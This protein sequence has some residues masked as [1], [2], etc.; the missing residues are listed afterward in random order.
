M[1]QIFLMS[2]LLFAS[3]SFAGP[4]TFSG[5]EEELVV[6]LLTEYISCTPMSTNS[7]SVSKWTY[8]FVCNASEGGVFRVE[9]LTYTKSPEHRINEKKYILVMPVRMEPLIGLGFFK[10]ETASNLNKMKEGCTF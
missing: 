2:V 6:N 1:K 7:N 5:T 4:D 9:T 8:T 10:L 3:S